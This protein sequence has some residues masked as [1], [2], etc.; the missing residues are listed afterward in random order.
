MNSYN[1]TYK[2]LLQGSL[3]DTDADVEKCC[4]AAGT[5]DAWMTHQTAWQAAKNSMEVGLLSALLGH[6]TI[7]CMRICLYKR[8]NILSNQ[9]ESEALFYSNLIVVRCMIASHNLLST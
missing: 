6:S 4:E 7:V 3:A 2:Q 9:I 8:V 1:G 5:A